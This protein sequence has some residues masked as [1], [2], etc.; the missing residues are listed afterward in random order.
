MNKSLIIIPVLFLVVSS[1]THVYSETLSAGINLLKDN[2][3]RNFVLYIP[4]KVYGNPECG[5]LFVAIHG[6]STQE[7]GQHIMKKLQRTAMRWKRLAD[8]KNLVILAPHF[9]RKHF[10]GRYQRLNIIEKRNQRAKIRADQ[11]LHQLVSRTK[12]LLPGI[13]A[14]TYY[15][16]GFSGGGQFTLRYALF[17][18]DKIKKAVIG[19][20]GWYTYPDTSLPYPIGINMPPSY[21]IDR[22]PDVRKF[23]SK[24]LCVVVGKND[25]QQGAFRTT[26]R[27]YDLMKLQGT[28]RKERA[29]KFYSALRKEA[30]KRGVPCNI[31]LLKIDDTAHVISRPLRAAVEKFIS[32]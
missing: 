9:E 23:L 26:W 25:R 1:T 12:T 21:N 14:D 29:E 19:A 13:K 8:R 10:F 24:E 7:S 22:K 4:K 6:F 15:M 11:W 28:G 18:P 27:R 31:R 32:E 16:F 2:S 3:G 5:E 30:E 17:Y 20:P